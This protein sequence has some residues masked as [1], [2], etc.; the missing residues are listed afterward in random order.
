MW[1][2]SG[3]AR[4]FSRA[5]SGL[6]F[7]QNCD[8]AGAKNCGLNL[9]FSPFFFPLGHATKNRYIRAHDEEEETPFAEELMWAQELPEETGGIRK[10][11]L[12]EPGI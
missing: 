10:K 2:R 4:I 11:T 5:Q 7:A 8:V 12:C 6:Y 1:P 9:F 3:N